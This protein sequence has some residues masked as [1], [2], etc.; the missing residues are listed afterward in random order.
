MKILKTLFLTC[1]SLSLFAQPSSMFVNQ[2]VSGTYGNSIMALRGIVF[3]N[4]FQENGSGTAAGTRNWQFNSD[5]YNNTWGARSAQTLSSYDA[6]IIPSTST[7]SANFVASGYNALGKL[8]ATQANYY[9]TYIIARGSS[10]ASQKMSVIETSFNPVTVSSVARTPSGP[11]TGGNVGATNPVVVNITL[12][13][14]PNAGEAIYVR[15]SVDNFSTSTLVSATGSATTW[16]AS[17]PAQTTGTTVTYY[18]LTA[19]LS[20]SF[21]APD[22]DFFT[23]E[24]NNNSGSNYSYTTNASLAVTYIDILAKPTTKGVELNWSTATETDNANFEIE[25]SNDG[26]VFNSIGEEKG[27]GNSK[28]VNTYSFTD[29][30]PAFGINYYRIVDVDYN[31]VKTT[32]KT[33]SVVYNGK[34]NAT[35]VISISPNPTFNALNIYYNTSLKENSTLIIC[36]LRGRLI[37]SQTI[38]ISNGS[39]NTLIDVSNLLSGV[40]IVR[41]NNDV[42]RFV[43]M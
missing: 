1:F 11:A 7:A 15:Y 8:A 36:D 34:S 20:S 29:A 17:I 22:S 12:S 19:K 42:Q 5:G 18:V 30:Q 39:S 38:N 10:Y 16:S 4:R 35:D 13:S 21:T 43:K 25:H 27:A 32:S 24:L 3:V 41:I 26:E 2:D 28:S 37:A 9:Y 40:Y 23:L 6:I 33:V 31:G 14:T